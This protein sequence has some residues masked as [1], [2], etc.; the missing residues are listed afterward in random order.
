MEF[1]ALSA[2]DLDTPPVFY[3]A[4]ASLHAPEDVSTFQHVAPQQLDLIVIPALGY[5]KERRR[6]GYGWGCYD[7]YLARVNED[8]LKIG[9]CFDDQLVEAL[10]VEPQDLPVD[11]VIT[12]TVAY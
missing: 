8:C 1:Y 2:S 4:P 3:T 9:V 6:I 12:P 11:V 5:D 10:P 7:R